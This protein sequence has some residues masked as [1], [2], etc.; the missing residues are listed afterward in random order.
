MKAGPLRG[1]FD[2]KRRTGV[3]AQVERAGLILSL[4]FAAA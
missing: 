2:L 1:D 4:S 3:P